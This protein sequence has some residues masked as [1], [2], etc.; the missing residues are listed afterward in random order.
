VGK[1]GV[2]VHTDSFFGR[3]TAANRIKIALSNHRDVIR[4]RTVKKK[5]RKL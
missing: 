1:G 3:D 4:P 2:V 5:S